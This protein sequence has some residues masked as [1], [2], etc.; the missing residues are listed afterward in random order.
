MPVG[1]KVE[2]EKRKAGAGDRHGHDR[3]PKSSK[4]RFDLMGSVDGLLYFAALPGGIDFMNQQYRQ[5]LAVGHFPDHNTSPP[6]VTSSLAD[7]LSFQV[8]SCK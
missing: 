3:V 5:S 2:Q 7:Y 1:I 4:G 6:R 8:V